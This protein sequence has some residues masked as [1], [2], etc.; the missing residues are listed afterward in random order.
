MKFI[1]QYIP[2]SKIKPDLSVKMTDNLKKLRRLMWDSMHILAVRKNG[3]DGSY[4]VV[5]GL[6]RYE[7]LSKHTN[8]K[9]APCII[10]D[11]ETATELNSWMYRLRNR[12]LL[13]FFPNIDQKRMT[14]AGLSII[15]S[16]LKQ[17]PRFR[18]LSVSQQIKV[19]MIAVRY[20]KTMIGSM[21]MMVDDLL[22]TKGN[23]K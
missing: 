4:I 21:R 13:S 3:K 7:Y 17:E 10:E 19:L 18:Q 2:M 12:R 16:F 14:P 15:R 23:G 6:D 11:R 1:V 22:K 9:Y 5:S 20:K 8:K